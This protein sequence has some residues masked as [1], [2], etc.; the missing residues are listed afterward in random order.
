MTD[1]HGEPSPLDAAQCSGCGA[2]FVASPTTIATAC[3]WCGSRLVDTAAAPG[4]DRIVPFRVTA[5]AA[6]QRLRTHLADSVW[7]PGEVRQLARSGQ[8]RPQE[9]RGVLVPYFVYRATIDARWRARIGIDWW[10]SEKA[11]DRHGKP[12]TRR[13][14]E[15]EWFDSDGTAVADQG[16]HQECASA[17][18]TTGEAEALGRFDLGRAVLF[19]PKILA[20]FGAELPTRRR[21]EVDAD[22]RV[23]IRRHALRRLATRVLPGEHHDV[24]GFDCDVTLHTLEVVLMPVWV[25]TYRHRGELCRLLVHGETG[26]CVGRPPISSVK[27]S[28][29]AAAVALSIVILLWLG[30][31]WS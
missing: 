4:V 29:A 7:A 12:T 27:V 10:R 9:L 3:G 26:A 23:A 5:R 1:V 17:T 13:V 28:L 8:L 11:V 2:Q 30:G 19:D 14:R 20:G 21:A 15:T 31:A 18:L 22:A 24:V 6:H 25:A 16:G